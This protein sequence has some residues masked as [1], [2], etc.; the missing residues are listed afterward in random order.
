MLLLAIYGKER[1]GLGQTDFTGSP[2]AS[3]GKVWKT[4]G[5][6]CH[7]PWPSAPPSA[8][9]FQSSVHRGLQWPGRHPA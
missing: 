6:P 4:P 2:Q 5:F 1:E 7:C 8:Q 9:F 3:Q